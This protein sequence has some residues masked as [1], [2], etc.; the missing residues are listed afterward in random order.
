[1][2]S[3]TEKDADHANKRSTAP[4][5]ARDASGAL[6]CPPVC[7]TDSTLYANEGCTLFQKRRRVVCALLQLP[8]SSGGR[9]SEAA[10]CP[11]FFFIVRSL[12][13]G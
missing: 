6:P 3:Q 9:P 13:V 2:E 7:S 1:M 11:E 10:R 8:F 4:T 12:T 5:S